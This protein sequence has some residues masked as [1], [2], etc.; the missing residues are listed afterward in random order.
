[1]AL[2]RMTTGN[3]FKIVNG[4]EIRYF[5][6]FYSDVNYLGGDLIWVFNIDKETQNLDE[7]IN[8]GY[9]FCF[10]TALNTG[11]KMKKWTLMGNKTIPVEM[12]Y[13]PKF[14][15]RDLETHDWYILQYD[16]KIKIGKNLTE[17]ENKIPVVTFSFPDG[18]IDYIIGGKEKFIINTNNFH[19]GYFEKNKK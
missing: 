13:Y 4:I 10:Y 17:E 12:Q 14:R 18:A 7:I 2:K 6:Y 3:I 15:W 19:E 1:M 11:I 5:Q 8:S 9:S 16:K